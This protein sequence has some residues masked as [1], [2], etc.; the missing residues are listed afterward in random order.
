MVRK[1]DLS[2][3]SLKKIVA[4]ASPVPL[5]LRAILGNPAK[6]LCVGEHHFELAKAGC[7]A[8]ATLRG[9]VA[10]MKAGPSQR[11]NTLR[12]TRP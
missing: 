4:K 12:A 6:C 2:P 7:L 9:A 3:I 10:V 5:K 11:S 1:N 8:L